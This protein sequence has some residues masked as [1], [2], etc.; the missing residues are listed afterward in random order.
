MPHTG[1]ATLAVIAQENGWS[2]YD[3]YAGPE[4]Q[5]PSG[6]AWVAYFRSG[7]QVLIAWSPLGAAGYVARITNTRGPD[8][9]SGPDRQN[10]ARRWFESP[11]KQLSPA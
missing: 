1:R 9:A 10:T 11:A 8:V 4:L 2:V 7:E 5:L 3:D 6:S